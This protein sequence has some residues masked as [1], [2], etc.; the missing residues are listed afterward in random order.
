MRK[1]AAMAEPSP[2]T[3]TM[4]DSFRA[5]VRDNPGAD[6]LITSDDRLTYGALDRAS[7]R[8]ATTLYKRGVQPQDVVG[9]A[10]PRSAA[11]ISAAIGVLKARGV[12]LMIDSTHPPM[13][14]AQITTEAGCAFVID[15]ETELSADDAPAPATPPY[16]GDGSLGTVKPT[17]CASSLTASGNDEP[18]CSIRKP[19]AVPCAPQP[20]Q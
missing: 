17:D 1:A 8:W 20:K 19:M 16:P 9:V 15:G 4:L 18:T 2:L 12:L 13:R 11:A 10:L 7:D 14:R 3:I 5:Q 6:A